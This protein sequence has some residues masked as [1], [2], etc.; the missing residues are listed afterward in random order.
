MQVSRLV[1][2]VALGVSP[3]AAA[4]QAP[5]LPETSRAQQQVDDL[6]RSINAQQRVLQHSQQNQ[7][8]VNQLRGEIQR[9]NTVGPLPIGC[10]PGAIRC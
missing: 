8:E 4:A 7:F 5:P 10:A 9:Q 3:V 1:L 6:S 2:T